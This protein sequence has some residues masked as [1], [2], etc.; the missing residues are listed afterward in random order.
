MRFL[1]V[2]Q[3]LGTPD[4]VTER[5][6][7]KGVVNCTRRCSDRFQVRTCEKA[8]FKFFEDHVRLRRGALKH[9]R[10]GDARIHVTHVCGATVVPGRLR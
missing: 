5:S 3:W 8:H 9:L 6:K 7:K 1:F 4:Q 2:H 10:V